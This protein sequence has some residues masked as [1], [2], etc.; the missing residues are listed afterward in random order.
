[1]QVLTIFVIVPE[2]LAAERE[3]TGARK[4]M[5]P[6]EEYYGYN[7]KVMWDFEGIM[8]YSPIFYGYYSS[9][10]STKAGYQIP[11]AYFCA[12]MSV[13]IF[14]FYIILNLAVGGWFP[15]SVDPNNY[16]NVPANVTA[17]PT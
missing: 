4:K 13:Y 15:F 8:R 1:M 9:K 17:L 16:E 11:L 7:L 3:G 12:G 5:L 14:S 6:V 2:V 10:G